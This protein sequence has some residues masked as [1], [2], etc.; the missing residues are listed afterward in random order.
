[1]NV[2][3]AD[4]MVPRVL[5]AMPSDKVAYVREVMLG[6]SIHAIPVIDDESRPV[7]IVTSSDLVENLSGD[8]EVGD[9]MT[10][11]VLTGPQYDDVHVAARM[12]RNH[13]LHHLI[14]THE[15]EIVGILSSFDLLQVIEDYRFR[16]TNPPTAS[17]RKGN[18]RL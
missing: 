15:G 6:Q 14:V 10:S 8:L 9:I 16:M 13:G 5:V 2:K 7:G 17:T 18:K 3:V 12:M 11:H 4:L 1:M